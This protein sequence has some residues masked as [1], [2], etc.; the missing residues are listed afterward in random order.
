ME[1]SGNGYTR[2]MAHAFPCEAIVL[3]TYDVG[4][5]DRFCVL[6]TRERGRM[7]ARAAGV[8]KPGSRIGGLVLPFRHLSVELRE[9]S[10]GCFI[11]SVVSR[12]ELPLHADMAAFTRVEQGC[13]LLL[14]L[15]SHE[16]PD[17]AVFDAFLAFLR[18]SHSPCSLHA[19]TFRLLGILGFLPDEL[20][21]NTMAR[22]SEEGSAFIASAREGRETREIP[23]KAQKELRKLRHLLLAE[24]LSSPLKAEGVA[25]SFL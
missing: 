24:H 25:G 19:F 2:A 8:R 12:S 10:A 11:R 13:E 1:L 4:E 23:E 5:A 21:L 17:T 22:L 18:S 16:E 14:A 3:R 6:F 9:G 7:T 20:H 15:V